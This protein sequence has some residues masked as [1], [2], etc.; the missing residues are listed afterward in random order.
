MQY[1]VTVTLTEQVEV[2][3]DTPEAA[4]ELAQGMDAGE[5]ARTACDWD[6][7]PADEPTGMQEG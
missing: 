7:T 5:F 2:Y 6:A 4:I 3:A 1:L